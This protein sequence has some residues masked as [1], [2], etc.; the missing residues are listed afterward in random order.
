MKAITKSRR[1]P[2]PRAAA[3]SVPDGGCSISQLA[4]QLGITQRTIRFYESRGLISP[5]RNGV[6]RVYSAADRMRLTLILRTKNLGFS[7]EEIA[8]HLKLYDREPSSPSGIKLRLASV[9]EAIEL[10]D[11][12]L[13][14]LRAAIADLRKIR[15]RCVAGLRRLR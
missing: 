14:D 7:L 4:A 8:T 2:Q 11:A 9:D 10:L 1:V 15:A 5:A 3:P 13:A 12:K 6:Q